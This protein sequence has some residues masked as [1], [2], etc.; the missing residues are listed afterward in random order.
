[1]MT[2]IQKHNLVRLRNLIDSAK[3]K[4]DHYTCYLNPL[5]IRHI[6]RFIMEHENIGIRLKLVEHDE[7]EITLEPSGHVGVVK[8]NLITAWIEF[9][10]SIIR[11]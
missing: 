11:V 4:I 5:I 7:V 2:D 10:Q 9:K 1:M 3:S 6:L 8:C